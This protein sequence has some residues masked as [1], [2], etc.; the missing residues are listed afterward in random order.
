[1]A[2]IL[3][4]EAW[5]SIAARSA[6]QP[7]FTPDSP[8]VYDGA[9]VLDSS[10]VDI[11]TQL[12]ETLESQA[13]GAQLYVVT[14]DSLP[15][16]QTIE[17]YSIEQAQRIG[18]GDSEKDNCVLYTF[19]ENTRQD[20]LEVEYGLEDRL[21][22]SVCSKILD[23]AHGYYRDADIKAGVRDLARDVA[24]AIQPGI[25]GGTSFVPPVR[26]EFPEKEESILSKI[27]IGVLALLY[28]TFCVARAYYRDDLTPS[29]AY[30]SHASSSHHS[31]SSSSHSS[32]HR[33]GG[34]HF[35]GGGASGGW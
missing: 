20:R 35:G 22:D 2:I 32:S 5:S 31:H 16:G 6:S 21:T 27:A 24:N 10:V 14:I 33:S 12:N 23:R 15:L 17:D 4:A 30:R 8:Y 9:D 7:S 26:H 29:S 25:D 1:M 13:D 3:A 11:L 19:V 28:L 34:G 18:A